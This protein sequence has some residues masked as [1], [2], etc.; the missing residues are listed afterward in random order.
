MVIL[1][2]KALMLPP[3]PPYVEAGPVSPPPFPTQHRPPLTLVTLPP[4]IL[5]RVVYETF[6]QGRVEKQRKVLYWLTLSLRLVNRAMYIAC[7]HVLRSTYLPLYTSLIRSPY[8]SDP[9][10]HAASGT[11][12]LAST[13][14][15]ATSS[16]PADTSQREMRVLD[17]FIALKVR[18]DVWTDDSELHLEREESFKD[19]FDLLQPRARLEDLVHHYGARDGV[20]AVPLSS[21][22]TPIRGS[23][24]SG[25]VAPI[26]FAA[27]TASFSPRAVGLVLTTKE[28]KRKI[29]EVPRARDETLEVSAKKLVRE[30]KGWLA[31]NPNHGVR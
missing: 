26:P 25:T 19:L 20:I 2:E 29:V 30:L 3:P 9:F 18:E 31:S 7:M 23:S 15:S 1:D 22:L 21:G 12:S 28:R 10:P 5:L 4:H 14:A 11:S 27:L 17:L 24:S 6:S 13:S 8:T 16:S